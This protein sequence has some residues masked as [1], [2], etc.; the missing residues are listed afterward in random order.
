MTLNIFDTRQEA[1]DMLARYFVQ[2]ANDAIEERNRFT[3][4]LAGGHTPEALYGLL[5]GVYRQKVSDWQKVYF[6]FGDERYVPHTAPE[7]N[8]RMAQVSLLEPLSIPGNHAFPVNTALAPEAAARAYQQQMDDFFLSHEIRFDLILLGLGD[9]AH[10]ASL[11]PYTEVLKD[12]QAGVKAVW[13][14]D[15]SGWRITLN[16]PLINQARNIAFLVFGAEK[17]AAMQHTFNPVPDSD[18]Y[19]A[20]LI[21]KERIAWFTDK[22]AAALIP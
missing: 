6:F 2:L 19:P 17:A 11:F 8:Y 13:T 14:G 7:S 15:A 10:T 16:A 3:V 5:A 20:Q 18:Q 21:R 4:A 9:N 22:D 1:L 12:T